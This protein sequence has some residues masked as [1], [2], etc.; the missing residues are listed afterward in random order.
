MAVPKVRA[1]LWRDDMSKELPDHF[2]NIDLDEAVPYRIQIASIA[3]SNPVPVVVI[4]AYRSLT[5][6]EAARLVEANKRS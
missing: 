3:F 5:T 6:G 1:G 4:T 2:F